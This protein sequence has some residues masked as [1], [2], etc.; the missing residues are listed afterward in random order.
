MYAK[1]KS[2]V[3]EGSSISGLFPCNIGVRQGENL[4]PL[5]FALYLNDF[6]LSI[7][8]KFRGLDFLS[9]EIKEALSD[10]NVEYFVRIFCLLYADDT[11]VLAESPTELQSAL[12]AVH[13]YCQEW[14]LSVNITK[15]KVVMFSR[16]RVKRAP[17]FLFGSEPLEMV[18]EYTYLGTVFSSN[19]STK[20]AV[21][22]QITGK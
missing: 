6:E 11:V 4:S 17:T 3:Q 1:A 22:K 9:N 21:I 14:K 5:L 19:G 16:G 15:T 18:H 2:C 7:S 10:D 20:A 12:D 8:K 13:S